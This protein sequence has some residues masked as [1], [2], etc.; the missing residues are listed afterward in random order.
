MSINVDARGMAC[1]QP[2]LAAKK[3]L[4]S[5]ADG[6]VT[7]IVD[8]KVAKEN[9]LKFAAAN[10]CGAVVSETDGHFRLTITKGSGAAGEQP[11]PQSPAHPA[12]VYLIT[13]NT[14][15]HGNDE[16]GA[17]LMKSFLYT[18]VETEPKPQAL[19]FINSG[20]LLT[21][22][23]SPVLGHLQTLAGQDVQLLSCGTCLDYYQLKDKLAAGTVTNMY[24]IVEALSG[25]GK[26]I[27]L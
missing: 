2:V 10:N 24:T 25:A 1:P 7:V 13:K 4:D 26:A 18:L 9:V 15:G 12:V 20:V 16:L 3:A 14:L 8:N 21:T 5:I 23:G 19:L 27:T 17:V 22:E 11:L 6:V